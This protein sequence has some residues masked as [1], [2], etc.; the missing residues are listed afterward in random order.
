MSFAAL[1]LIEPLQRVLDELEHRTPTPI[2]RQAIPPVLAGR[3]LIAAAQTG[4]GKTASFALPLLQKLS[5]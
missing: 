2:Q 5:P 3:D 4:S 1:G